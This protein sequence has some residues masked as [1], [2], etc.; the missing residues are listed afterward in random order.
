M[1]KPSPSTPRPRP[2]GSLTAQVLRDLAERIERGELQPGDRL[3]PERSLMQAYN[4]SRTVVREAISSL[5][6]SGRV[7]TQQGRGAF[8]LAPQIALHYEIDLAEADRIGEILQIMDLRLALESEAAAMVARQRTEAQMESIRAA[9]D[10]LAAEIGNERTSVAADVRFHLEIIRA[11][12]NAWF[13]DLF[14]QL[15]PLLIPRGRVD[16][17]KRDRD[18]KRRYLERIQQEHAQ[19]LEAIERRDA[20]AARAAVR[21]HLSNSR[22]RLRAAL[23][24]ARK[25]PRQGA[26]RAGARRR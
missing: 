16:L 21:L 13:Q 10:Q 12:G 8:V 5:R 22:E 24:L 26:A 11:T 25:R 14:R 15:A 23:T 20:D 2:R 19:M 9:F 7:D 4:V 1:A 3:P 6:A 18:E 17:F